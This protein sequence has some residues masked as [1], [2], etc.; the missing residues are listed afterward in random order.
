MTTAPLD[1]LTPDNVGTF[2][3]LTESGTTYLFVATLAHRWYMYRTP[4]HSDILTTLYGDETWLPF[5]I[6]PIDAI[7]VGAHATLLFD[8][9]ELVERFGR[10]SYLGTSR[11]TARVKEIWSLTKLPAGIPQPGTEETE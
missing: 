4:R 6:G 9:P 8:K 10:H 5:Y 7:R 2:S 11:I 3:I 1:S